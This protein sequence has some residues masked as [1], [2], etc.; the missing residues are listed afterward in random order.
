MRKTAGYCYCK[1]AVKNEVVI[2]RSVRIVLSTKVVDSA[3]KLRDTLLHEMCHAA[4][5]MVDKIHNGHGPH[6]RAW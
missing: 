1:R 4:T 2:K 5:W 6:W 3:E